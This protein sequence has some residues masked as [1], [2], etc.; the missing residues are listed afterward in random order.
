MFG[1]TPRSFIGR[2]AGGNASSLTL[3]IGEASTGNGTVS[4]TAGGWANEETVYVGRLS[5]L[6]NADTGQLSVQSGGVL[7]TGTLFVSKTGTVTLTTTGTTLVEA[8][9]LQ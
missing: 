7:R 3:L 2:N 6:Q 8:Y 5:L 9:N 4:I 1:S